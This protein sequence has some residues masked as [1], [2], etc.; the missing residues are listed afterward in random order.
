MMEATS[1]P[2]KIAMDKIL[3]NS[4]LLMDL[5]ASAGPFK[6]GN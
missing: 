1:G 3:K 6:D 4:A 5:T 2:D